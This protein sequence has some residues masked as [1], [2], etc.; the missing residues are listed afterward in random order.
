MSPRRT[1]GWCQPIRGHVG[2]EE[3]GMT[4]VIGITMQKRHCGYARNLVRMKGLFE[5]RCGRALTDFGCRLWFGEGE[6]PPGSYWETSTSRAPMHSVL[7]LL[8]S[9]QRECGGWEGVWEGVPYL[10]PPGL[11]QGPRG[12]MCWLSH[13]SPDTAHGAGAWG[14]GG[15]SVGCAQ[16]LFRHQSRQPGYVP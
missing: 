7:E 13:A 1:A 12:G 6:I 8:Q 15:I 16:V 3:H 4:L 11:G 9:P 2:A 10:C 14:G 5:G